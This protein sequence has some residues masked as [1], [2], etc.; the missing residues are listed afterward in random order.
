MRSKLKSYHKTHNSKAFA[1]LGKKRINIK[2]I[3]KERLF[4]TEFLNSPREVREIVE[5]CKKE[6]NIK[7]KGTSVSNALKRLSEE[8]LIKVTNSGNKGFL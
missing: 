1:I 5:Y 3:I 4:K 6:Y 8:G 7:L 2:N